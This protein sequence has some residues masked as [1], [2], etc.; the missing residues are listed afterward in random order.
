MLTSQAI[1]GYALDIS[2]GDYAMRTVELHRSNLR[3]LCIFLKDPPIEAITLDDLKLFMVHLKT[4]YKPKRRNGSTAP[5]AGASQDNHWKAMRTFFRWASSNIPGIT[6]VAEHLPRPAYTSQETIPFTE[7]DIKR[8]LAALDHSKT[9][10]RENSKEYHLRRPTA[11]RDKVIIM[12]LLDTGVRVGELCRLQLCDI[13]LS[14]GEVNIMPFSTGKKTK[15][16]IVHLG[17]ATRRVLWLYLAKLGDDD[18]E[19][20]LFNI[21]P[22]PIRQMLKELEKRSGVR[23]IHPHRFRHTFALEYLRNGGDVFTLQRLLGHRSLEMVQHY[24]YLA[25]ADIGEAHRKASPV[26][27]WKL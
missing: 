4:T 24:L 17:K 22:T 25:K 27:R 12:M 6:N 2:S 14:T 11:L 19:Q 8:M 26:D 5:L 15:A 9:F 7:D 16:R 1:E 20:R 23:N 21:G 3:Q 10:K 18:P 13:D